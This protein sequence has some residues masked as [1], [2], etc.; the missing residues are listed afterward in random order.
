[1]T[2]YVSSGTLNHTHS[3]THSTTFQ[4]NGKFNGLYLPNK[5]TVNVT[6]IGQVRWRLQGVSYTS[7]RNVMNVNG[8]QTA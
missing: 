1:M 2:Y 8:P 7:P 3:L 4:L 5:T 6:T